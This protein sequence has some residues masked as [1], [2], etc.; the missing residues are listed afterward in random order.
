MKFSSLY[1]ALLCTGS[2]DDVERHTIGIADDYGHY[3]CT[4]CGHTWGHWDHA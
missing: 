4:E 1:H 2:D 3:E